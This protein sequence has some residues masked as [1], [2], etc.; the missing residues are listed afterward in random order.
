MGLVGRQTRRPASSSAAGAATIPDDDA[1]AAE[2][3]GAREAAEEKRFIFVRR[4]AA[5]SDKASRVQQF[6]R[7]TCPQRQKPRRRIKCV[8]VGRESGERSPLSLAAASAYRVRSVSEMYPST[9]KP[10]FSPPLSLPKQDSAT[11][12][13]IKQVCE[14]HGAR[15]STPQAAE[16]RREM[17]LCCAMA[18]V[19]RQGQRSNRLNL[20]YSREKNLPFDAESCC[21]VL[22]RK[23]EGRRSFTVLAIQFGPRMILSWVI[24]RHTFED[25]NRSKVKHMGKSLSFPEAGK[26]RFFRFSW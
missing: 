19:V 3:E 5:P 11:G 16:K 17:N 4:R 18:A 1:S 24:K 14:D 25:E 20:S 7:L 26:L 12:H 22:R 9:E 13:G 23:E 10:T 8:R 2:D 6:P 21:R 15:C